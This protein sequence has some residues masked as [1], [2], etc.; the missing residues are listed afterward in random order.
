MASTTKETPYP[1]ERDQTETE[2]LNTQH[3]LLVRATG[4]LLHPSITRSLPPEEP[5]IAELAT[6]TGI[7]L[8]ELASH[9]PQGAKLD[10]YDISSSAFTIPEDL[11]S[12]V[13]LSILDAK[14]TPSPE[15]RGRYDAVHIR[16]MNVALPT[17]EDWELVARHAS[18][19][20]KPGG[21]LQWVE[22][23]FQGLTTVYSTEPETKT[24]ALERAAAKA[25]ELLGH[26]SEYPFSN[27]CFVRVS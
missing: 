8:I 4:S 19:L 12:N 2:R 23:G 16:F 13:S 14:Q 15:L 26:A 6:G 25:A 11:P 24:T 21:A 3:A 22:A 9:L 5:K 20:L 18:A 7:W 10:G 17:D 27:F 1:L